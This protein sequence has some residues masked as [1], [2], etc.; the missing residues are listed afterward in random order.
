[1][2][3]RFEADAETEMVVMVGEIG[4]DEEEKAARFIAAEMSKPVV[5]YI[6][7][8]SAPPGKTMGHAGAIITGSSGTAQAKKEALEASGVARRHVADR[9]GADRRRG[10]ARR[11][12]R[13]SRPS[14]D[15]RAAEPWPPRRLSRRI[16]AESAQTRAPA[17]G[18]VAGRGKGLNPHPGGGMACGRTMSIAGA[19]VRA[20]LGLDWGRGRDLLR[21]RRPRARLPPGGADRRLCARAV[22]ERDGK[23]ILNYGPVG[24]YGP[25]RE[26]VAAA[27]RRPAV[28]GVDHERVAPGTLPDRGPPGRPR[29]RVLV[30]GPTYDRALHITARH[31]GEPVVAPTDDEGLD[32]GALELPAAFLYTIPTFQN[33]SGRTLSLE[34]RQA[35]ASL[36]RDGKVLVLEDDPYSLVRYE[37]EPLPSVYELAAGEGVVY[38]FSFSKIVAPGLRVGYLVGSTELIGRLEDLAVQTYL[39]PALLPQATAYEFVAVDC[40]T[41]TSSA[42][43][44]CSASAVMRCSPRSRARCRTGASWSRPQGG[45][46]TWLDFPE[47]TDAG[48]LLTTA[49]ER[50]V[51]FVKGSD[52]YPAGAGGDASARLA[53]SFVSPAEVTA[54]VA[55]LGGVL[56]ELGATPVAV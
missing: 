3:G 41:P 56:R 13:R 4:G 26:W 7:G 8:F 36:A 20:G 21:A 14:N 38:S 33:P 39:T 1:M 17:R 40:S 43:S 19:P 34:R 10:A 51:T 35:L 50:G 6:A 16:G 29:R 52:F 48:A 44:A 55:L 46:F 18:S 49:T 37:G 15:R 47:G 27:A 24:G 53:F 2:L 45:Y 9:G 31:H 12:G 42:S 5:A 30:E 11:V 23:T 22:V 28:A 54:G 25:L 32:P